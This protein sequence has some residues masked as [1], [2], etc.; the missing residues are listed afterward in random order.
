LNVQYFFFGGGDSRTL[1]LERE[2]C[3]IRYEML[4]LCILPRPG[5]APVLPCVDGLASSAA[6]EPT[7]E[8]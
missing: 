7:Y 4:H 8:R 5:A 6:T 2:S 1:T 3:L